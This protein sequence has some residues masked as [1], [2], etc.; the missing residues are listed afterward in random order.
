MCNGLVL[1]GGGSKG[2]YQIGVL[3][4]LNELG[5]NYKVVTGTSVGA[6]NTLLLASHKQALLEKI[7]TK[8]E[9]ESIIGHEYKW[10]SKVLET[11]IKG[12]L[13]GGLPLSPLENLIH[14]HVNVSELKASDIECGIV[15]TSPFRKYTPIIIKQTQDDKILDYLITSCSAFP[16]LKKR[17]IDGKK[18]YDGFYTDNL[19][20][21][22]AKELGATK[23]I[24]ID[25]L[26]GFRQK[27]DISDM[28]YL[29]IKPTRKT[30]F[31]LNFDNDNVNGLIELGYKDVMDRK[32]EILE[33]I[34]S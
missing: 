15:F 25:V 28:K 1:G 31:F 21:K 24:A 26:K 7:W 27:V 4:A 11:F 34:N 16:F 2:A 3:R 32:E 6:L 20:V 17:T 5:Y 19:P 14:E 29:C 10:N 12:I 22:L 23:V 33:F 8:I 18:C 30:G 13:K 9:F